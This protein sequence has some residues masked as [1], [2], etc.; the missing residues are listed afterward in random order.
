[1]PLRV[2]PPHPEYPAAHPVSSGVVA[3]VLRSFFGTKKITI[4][5]TPVVA[6]Y[7]AGQITF[8]STDDMI[9]QAIEARIYGGMHYRTSGVHGALMGSKVGKWATKHYFLP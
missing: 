1:V 6:G 2:T 5:F 3:E 8:D 9:K 4:S 7:T